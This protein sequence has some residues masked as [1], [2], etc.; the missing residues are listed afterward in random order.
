[1]AK[2]PATVTEVERIRGG[3]YQVTVAFWDGTMGTY[4][5]PEELAT[6]EAV[7]ISALVF[8]S[9]TDKYETNLAKPHPNPA[10]QEEA[11]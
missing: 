2:L 3:M 7:R 8:A 9:L 6:Y 11:T 4:V 10:I 1:M 5:V